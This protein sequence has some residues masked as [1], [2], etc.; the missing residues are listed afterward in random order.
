MH[1]LLLIIT[2]MFGGQTLG[3]LLGLVKRPSQRLLYSSLAFAGSMMLA[4]SLI[5]LIPVSLAIAPAGFVAVCFLAGV[6]AFWLVDRLLPH[7]HPELLAMDKHCP[8]RCANMLVIGMAIHNLP[9]GLA[10]GVGFA[11]DP[12]MGLLIA[13]AMTVQDLPENIATIVP[14][15][16]MNK[17]RLRS[18]L[19]VAGTVLFELFG[20]IAGY[21]FLRD[22]S[23]GLISGALSLA[24]GIMTY[25][26]IDELIPAARIREDPKAGIAALALGALTFWAMSLLA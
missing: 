5:K 6:L 18:F 11:T 7:I 26:V 14:L 24:A 4:I 20:F 23:A 17:K 21:F 8:R 10:V 19:I 12:A 22:A 25:I 3:C 2:L 1:D 9:E 16:N 15:Y 13:A